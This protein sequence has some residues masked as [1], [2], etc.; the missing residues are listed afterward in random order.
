MKSNSKYSNLNHTN[1]VNFIET[2]L[3]DMKKFLLLNVL[4]ISF[5]ASAQNYQTIR[6]NQISYYAN[7]DLSY[8]LATRTDSFDLQGTDSIFYSYKTIRYNDTASTES[9]QHLVSPN[10]YGEKVIIKNN[11][12]TIFFNKNSD[13]IRIQTQ[14]QFQDTFLVYVYPSGLDSIFAAV[15]DEDTLTILGDL[16]SIK[17]LQFFNNSGSFIVPA[18]ASFSKNHGFYEWFASYSF[19]DQYV[20]P[21]G[22]NFINYTGNFNLVGHE[23]PRVG[24]TK[25]R[26]GEIYDFEEEDFLIY[27]YGEY[28]LDGYSIKTHKERTVISKT[29][30]GVDSVYYTYHDTLRTIEQDNGFGPPT[31]YLGY[32]ASAVYKNL[33]SMN[34]SLLPEEFNFT[35]E[36]S[37][38]FLGIND[39]ARLQ[40]TS[41]ST[42]INLFNWPASNCVVAQMLSF[43][44]SGQPYIVGNGTITPYGSEPGYPY[45]YNSALS[46]YAKINEDTCGTPQFLDLK[47]LTISEFNFS[48]FPNPTNGD[49]NIVLNEKELS[50]YK[51]MITDLSG[52]IIFETDANS[53]E[54][55]NG[56]LL[57]TSQFESGIYFVI[58][59]NGETSSTVK[60]IKQ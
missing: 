29:L 20:G 10:W 34:D 42:S 9:C 8:I 3:L 32:N 22:A 44:T 57:N 25:P 6:S 53:D 30:F 45:F 47:N 54:L 58:L 43:Y 37:W 4:I 28:D 17:T 39:C 59:F 51:V 31:I 23:F 41:F 48:L 26:I 52:K 33:L 11:G 15:I 16:D 18:Q 21:Q 7:P 36:N 46:Y 19:P 5:C 56:L 38:N 14:A 2:Y 35:T 60:L 1:C 13:S 50:N 55:A 12:H 24:I 49:V 27:D 40:E